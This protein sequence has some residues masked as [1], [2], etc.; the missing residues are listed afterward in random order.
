MIDILSIGQWIG[1][2][3]A[4]FVLK[5]VRDKLPDVI[6]LIYSFCGNL[7]LFKSLIGSG[8][9]LRPIAISSGLSLVL[10]VVFL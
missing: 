4:A 9:I 10:M 6:G 3:G 1:E 2:V 7:V 8:N 5:P